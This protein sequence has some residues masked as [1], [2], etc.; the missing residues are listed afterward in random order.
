MAMVGQNHWP[1]KSKDSFKDCVT[2]E[3][4]L[5]LFKQ[6]GKNSKKILTK[7]SPKAVGM[8]RFCVSRILGIKGITF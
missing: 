3:L 6:R 7:S 8:F 4:D 2:L 1:E 5:G